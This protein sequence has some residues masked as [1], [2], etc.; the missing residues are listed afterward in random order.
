[1]Y[2]TIRD[3]MA[4]IKGIGAGHVDQRRNGLLGRKAWER[5][6]ARYESLK[7]D[8]GLPVT[9]EVIIASARVNMA[10]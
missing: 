1:F 3:V 7:T 6:Q 9:Y 2:P 5:I 4:S 8:K 10:K